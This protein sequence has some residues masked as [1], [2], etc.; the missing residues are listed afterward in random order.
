LD[1]QGD[2]IR[3]AP[4]PFSLW[5][6]FIFV[7]L[8][9]GGPRQTLREFLG[10]HYWAGFAGFPF[11]ELTE[12]YSVRADSQ[13]NWKSMND[14]FAEVY[15]GAYTHA[16]MS[17]GG[18]KLVGQ[19]GNY[20]FNFF[21]ASGKHRH[22]DIAGFAGDPYEFDFQRLTQAYVT[23]PRYRFA[24]DYSDLP[25][26]ANPTKLEVWGNT[27]DMFFPNTYIQFYWPGWFLTYAMWPL[28]YNR[29]RFEIDMWLPPSRNFSELL[30]HKSGT[31]QFLEAAIQD[32]SMLEATQLGLG[33]RA[34]KAYPLTDQE[35]LVRK[36]HEDIAAVVS[37]YQDELSMAQSGRRTATE[38]KMEG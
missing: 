29:M 10:E 34:F 4:V 15:H 25:V 5:N 7:N 13:S 6:G 37:A 33:N 23:G 1:N 36:F 22:Y 16:L 2:S 17:P 19:G 14:G 11:S 32:F 21:A 31:G 12:R 35:C 38:E 3:L 28:A 26:A 18:A 9:R 20:H 27:S 8:D 30:S 24:K